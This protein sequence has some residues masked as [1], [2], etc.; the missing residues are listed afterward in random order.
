MACGQ[1]AANADAHVALGAALAN[2]SKYQEA[3]QQLEKALVQAPPPLVPR[4]RAV[5]AC[6]VK[7]KARWPGSAGV[8]SVARAATHRRMVFRFMTR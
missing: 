3:L 6:S 7:A 5:C 2:T 4:V 8:R 1:D